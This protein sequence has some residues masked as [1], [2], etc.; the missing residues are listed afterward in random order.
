[1]A[2]FRVK[3]SPMQPSAKAESLPLAEFYSGQQPDYLAAS[4]VDYYS[5]V[6]RTHL[7]DNF[8]FERTGIKVSELRNQTRKT[9]LFDM[10]HHI[11]TTKETVYSKGDLNIDDRA[12]KKW[13]QVKLPLQ[14]KD[15]IN[16][17][18]T[19]LFFAS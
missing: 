10:L 3:L 6:L 11:L 16:E 5:G 7:V 2:F 18:L 13:Q 4:V 9:E 14:R 1:M 15:E 8:G 17:V 12:H 19:V